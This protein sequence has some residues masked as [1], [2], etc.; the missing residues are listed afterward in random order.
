MRY[1]HFPR[2]S[3]YTGCSPALRCVNALALKPRVL[4]DDTVNIAVSK[5]VKFLRRHFFK[6]DRQ[7]GYNVRYYAV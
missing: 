4:Y 1:E 3:Q 5:N 7:P 6:S 2:Y